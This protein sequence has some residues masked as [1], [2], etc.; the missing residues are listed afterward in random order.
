MSHEPAEHS[1]ET[2]PK[3][4]PKTD[5]RARCA[6]AI[7]SAIELHICRWAFFYVLATYAAFVACD[8]A[9]WRIRWPNG[10]TVYDFAM[11]GIGIFWLGMIGLSKLA[12]R[13]ASSPN[14]QSEPRSQQ[15]NQ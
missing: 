5:S 7:C 6:L 11:V 1:M 3:N 4:L 14:V 9:W 15:N 2:I 8:L 10:D 13:I 12:L